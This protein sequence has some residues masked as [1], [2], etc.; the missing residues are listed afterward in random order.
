MAR[1]RL[2]TRLARLLPGGRR[3]AEARGLLPAGTSA[4]WA[5]EPPVELPPG[6]LVHVHGRGE[7]FIRDSGGDGPPVLLLHGWMFQSDLNWWRV[8]GPLAEAGY[9]VLAI[10]DRG[11]GRGLR[12]HE[13]FRLSDC[14]E[15]AAAVVAE[16]GCGPVVAAGYSMGGAVAQLMARNHPGAVAGL[17]LGATS[18][19]WQD[20]RMKAIWT[21]M[22]GLRLT[23]NAFP[24]SVWR[25]AM[26]ANG[27]PDDATT[28]WITAELTRGDARDI[29][30]AGRELGR[31]DSRP[32]LRGLDVPAVVIVTAADS[33]VP[34]D[35]QH[36]LAHD[37]GAGVIEVDC[38]HFGVTME[39][40]RFGDVMV[41]AMEEV[42]RRAGRG[43]PAVTSERASA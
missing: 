27:F 13:P 39:Q 28:S 5:P 11:H 23:M 34:P 43:A 14:A 22:G 29:A 20:P 24:R 26:R 6:R 2:L 10:D 41:R 18:R 8:Y 9:R 19:E 12:T 36:A 30:E 31:Y 1:S 32:W 4:R 25:R 17:I 35:K 33:S 42:A 37:L 40:Y 3:R 15:D 21:G 16:L 38:D 7:F